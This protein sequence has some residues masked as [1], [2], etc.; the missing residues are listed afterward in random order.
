MPDQTKSLLASKTMWGVFLVLVGLLADSSPQIEQLL[1]AEWAG[2]I[3]I[4]AGLILTFA[5]RLTAT[6]VIDRVLPAL[7]LALGLV[8]VLLLGGCGS[9]RSA[10]SYRA[11]E[12]LYR[13]SVEIAT[14]AAAAGLM[15]PDQALRFEAARANADAMLDRWGELET[16]GRGDEFGG[17]EQLRRLLD[18]MI[19]LQ[20]GTDGRSGDSGDGAGRRDDRRAGSQTRRGPS[21][22]GADHRGRARADPR[23]PGQCERRLARAA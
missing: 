20:G 7:P 19:E 16:T 23:G 12:T 1:G 11:A 8:P 10:A 2:K 3:G 14:D 18:M 22:A 13:G 4:V 15:T 17:L 6:K 21:L 9:A 5:G